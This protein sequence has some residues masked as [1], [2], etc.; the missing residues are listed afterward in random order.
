MA[1]SPCCTS[2]TGEGSGTEVVDNGN[3]WEDKVLG[4]S[5]RKLLEEMLPLVAS[6][7][8]LQRLYSEF[9]LG[10]LIHLLMISKKKTIGIL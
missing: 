10:N 5:K 6:N 3:D 1:R 8:S 2:D 9:R 7:L 4:I